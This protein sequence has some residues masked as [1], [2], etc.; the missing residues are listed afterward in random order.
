[1][2]QFFQQEH[3]SDTQ[4][5]AFTETLYQ[6]L[7][8]L[9]ELIDCGHLTDDTPSIGAELE[10]YL[11]DEGFVP[12]LINQQL[13]ADINNPQL[14]PELNQYNLEFNLSPVNAKGSPFKA[15]ETELSQVLALIQHHAER[16]NAAVL[17][18]G[19]LP[20]I[21]ECDLDISCM[22]DLPRYRV[23]GRELAA[24]R[25]E[26]FQINIHG[27]DTLQFSCS[28]VTLEGV[29]TSF[30]L[31]FKVPPDQF[32]DM[33]NT[34][35]IITPLLVAIGANSPLCMGK[36]LWHESRIA[37]F[38]QS[39]DSRIRDPQKWRQPARV[40]FGHG[41]LRDSAWELFAENVA[42]YPP[43]I[44]LGSQ[45]PFSEL[46]MHHGTVWNWNRAVFEAQHGGHLRI[47]FRALPAG[48]TLVDMMANAAFAIGLTW[49]LSEQVN[50][51]ITQLP[52]NYAEHNFYRAAQDG[53]AAKILWPHNKQHQ[54][55]ERSVA[56]VVAELLPTAEIGLKDLGIDEREI[57][58]LLSVIANRVGQHQNG[59]SWQ[60]QKLSQYQQ[61]L[62]LNDALKHMLR[63][64]LDNMNSGQPVVEWK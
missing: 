57:S 3:F 35:Q 53:I 42:L 14:Q 32:K 8:Q 34:A 54:L 63:D 31:H 5:A 2:G 55:T 48:P 36:R 23:L 49:A 45:Q 16:L 38:K 40:S 24:L 41:W 51:L 56:D 11:V 26:P 60:L 50:T 20:T 21:R 18:I 28:E 62:P 12:K 46:C 15:M 64:Y 1:M 19:I 9:K 37:L 29:N 7:Q 47:E 59:A 22:T 4:Y 44:P 17:P 52:F 58:H 10:M 6:Q 61:R 33:F 27:Q 30:Q 43:I 25:G 39:I 13:I